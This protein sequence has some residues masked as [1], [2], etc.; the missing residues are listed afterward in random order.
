[1]TKEKRL[2]YIIWTILLLLLLGGVV[3]VGYAFHQ[4]GFSFSPT[5]ESY[6]EGEPKGE[7]FAVREVELGY[8]GS[9]TIDPSQLYLQGQGESFNP[10]QFKLVGEASVSGDPS[11]NSSIDFELNYR[12]LGAIIEV[13]END[14]PF[15]SDRSGGLFLFALGSR[16]NHIFIYDNQVQYDKSFS[17]EGYYGP[18]VITQTYTGYR[19]IPVYLFEEEYEP[20]LIHFYSIGK[21]D[22]PLLRGQMQPSRET[23]FLFN[24]TEFQKK[25]MESY[26]LHERSDEE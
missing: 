1:M 23:I 10:S 2:F 19:G 16:I 14:L 24:D 20:F 13:Y 4:L 9:I 5:K 18:G 17:L 22:F 3:F 8:L 6:Q 26:V 15:S 7:N 12:T 11:D 21:E 25:R